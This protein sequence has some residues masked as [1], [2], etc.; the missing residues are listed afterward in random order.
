[1]SQ[2]GTHEYHKECKKALADIRRERAKRNDEWEKKIVE[3]CGEAGEEAAQR[4][5]QLMRIDNLH[6]DQQELYV[7]S[8]MQLA[9]LCEINSTLM[10]IKEKV[11]KPI[12]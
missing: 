3:T 4:C 10:A 7:I 6:Y 1:M 9:M 2:P 8:N 11:R 5:A 12:Q